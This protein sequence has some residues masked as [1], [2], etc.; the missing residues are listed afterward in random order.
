MTSSDHLLKM[1][2]PGNEVVIRAIESDRKIKSLYEESYKMAAEIESLKATVSDLV[3]DNESIKNILDIKQNEWTKITEKQSSLTA[4][5]PET[6][7]KMPTTKLQNQL[8]TLNDESGE[9]ISSPELDS[10]ERKSENINSQI[11]NYRSKERSKF[12]NQKKTQTHKQKGKKKTGDETQKKEKI[13]KVLVIGDSMVK[14]I[15]RKLIGLQVASQSS[16]LT[17]VQEWNKSAAR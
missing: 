8:E 6:T 12:E 15:D 13:N 17:V 2:E 10:T 5:P 16:T 11:N 9:N 4:N 3:N 7:T 14:H 1:E